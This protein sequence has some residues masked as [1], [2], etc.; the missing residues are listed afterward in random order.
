MLN[1]ANVIIDVTD[2][3]KSGLL[4][5]FNSLVKQPSSIYFRNDGVQLNLRFVKPSVTSF[6]N[7]DDIVD[8]NTAVVDVAIGSYDLPPTIGTFTLSYGGAGITTTTALQYN[9]TPTQIANALNLLTQIIADGGVTV[10]QGSDSQSWIVK[11]NTPGAHALITGDGSLL[12]PLSNVVI[13]EDQLGTGSLPEVQIVS[14]RQVPAAF[15]NSWSN[16]ASPGAT[17]TRLQTGDATHF[18][19][20]LITLIPAPYDGSFIIVTASGSTAAIPYNALASDVAAALNAITGEA[21]K[22]S[23]TGSQGG[24]WTISRTVYVAFADPTVNSSGLI[25]PVGLTGVLQLNTLALYLLFIGTTNPT[26]T[27]VFE[28]AVTYPGQ[29]KQTVLSV[30]VTVSRDLINPA[31][32]L[33]PFLPIAYT[34]AQADN[35][36]ISEHASV[37][38]FTGGGGGNFDGIAT[39]TRPTGQVH[40]AT[41]SGTTYFWQLTAG[42]L[43]TSSP[44]I[45]RPTDYNA[46]T[47]QKYW[48]LL[49]QISSNSDATHVES[50]ST[51]IGNG[52]GIV[53]VVFGT[54]KVDANYIFEHLYL[55]NLT[56]NV[57]L[58]LG[59]VYAK[60][61]T[62]FSVNLTGLTTTA[63]WVLQWKVKD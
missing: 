24:P 11:W 35:I 55:E 28:V 37:S 38:G 57:A 61:T 30:P 34:T 7:W 5:S 45:I 16:F 19:I 54:T 59:T 42:N 8:I 27:L 4:Q 14:L 22:W 1:P 43:A 44:Q 25:V 10:V 32:L 31:T 18:P 49:G 9:S 21:G 56:D 23:V 52:V 58:A 20:W 2:T 47:N 51:A 53:S 48:N 33:A 12:L 39:A 17:V 40:V 26:I 29:L 62:G 63:N 41:V 36:F 15:Q 13:L 50:G 3:D 60:S 46:V 6:R